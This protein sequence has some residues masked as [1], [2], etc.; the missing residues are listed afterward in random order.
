MDNKDNPYNYSD[1]T[2]SH[3]KTFIRHQN[4]YNYQKNKYYNPRSNNYNEFNKKSYNET[5]TQFNRYSQMQDKDNQ[6]GSWKMNTVEINKMTN[7]NQE[8]NVQRNIENINQ[9]KNITDSFNNN[10]PPQ[11]TVN[12]INQTQT[13]NAKN[14]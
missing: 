13:E 3:R 8:N 4:N 12:T 9:N 14:K 10:I 1:S 5:R 6:Q 2:Y 11:I 7:Q